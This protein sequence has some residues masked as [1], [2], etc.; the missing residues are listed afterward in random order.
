MK[1]LLTACVLLLAAAPSYAQIQWQKTLESALTSGKETNKVVFLAVNMDGEKA[2]DRMATKMYAEKEV[3]ALAARTVNVVASAAEHAA[4]TKTCTRFPGVYCLDHRRVDM[5]ARKDVLKAD[6]S[7]MVIAP[8]HV[9]LSGNG[10]V[11]LSVPYEISKDEMVW[12]FVTALQKLDPKSD[13]VMPSTAR[14]PQRVVM[15]GVFDPSA[16]EAAAP[17]SKKELQELITKVKKGMPE[18]ER[19]AAIQR[20]LACDDQEA[21][22]YIETELR[23][24]SGGGRG[25]GGGGGGRGGGGGGAAGGSAKHR[26]IIKAIGISSPQ[27]YA[28]L[29]HEFVGNF[30]PEMRIEAAVA[31]EQLAAADST[32]V[33]EK[34]LQEEKDPKVQK[35][36]IRALAACGSKEAKVRKDIVRRARSEKDLLVRR[37]AI[38]ALS[39]FAPDGDCL[40]VLDA[41]MQSGSDE[42]K[43]TAALALA[44]RR[45]EAWRGALDEQVK[46]AVD[47]PVKTTIEAALAVSNGADLSTIGNTVA[48]LCKDSV[49]RVRTYGRPNARKAGG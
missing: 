27:I 17:L 4:A 38:F 28:T 37:N 43:R 11:L 10:Q 23:S 45:E 35:D 36:L 19:W 6:A 15:D 41:V 21:V 8:Q 44:I 31:L 25:G 42:D 1:H 2:N 9:W 39:N 22:D 40:A 48:A 47:G 34:Q 46:T 26:R 49:E 5:E 16:A 20:I 32:K 33:L 3:V 7:G 18:E 29:V 14:A 30:D 24:G 13:V 12:C